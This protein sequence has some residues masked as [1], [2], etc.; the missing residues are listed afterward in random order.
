MVKKLLNEQKLLLREKKTQTF[1][2][3]D[4]SLEKKEK[5]YECISVH[6]AAFYYALV[7]QKNV[8]GACMFN[9]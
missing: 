8:A 1:D 6:I 7:Q 9:F 4:S 5:K 2:I 3:P